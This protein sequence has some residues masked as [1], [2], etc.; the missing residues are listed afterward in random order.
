MGRKEK[1]PH[2]M[3]VDHSIKCDR[4][5]EEGPGED[6]SGEDMLR[7]LSEWLLPA[8]E[9]D[10]SWERFAGQTGFFLK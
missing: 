2:T 5:S 7:S 4:R 10:G 6:S 3:Y 8:K 1:C 9:L